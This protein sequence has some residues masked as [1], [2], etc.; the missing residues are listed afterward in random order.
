MNGSSFW[1][2]MGEGQTLGHPMLRMRL[3]P[4]SP[5]PQGTVPLSRATLKQ[6]FH[7]LFSQVQIGSFH[8]CFLS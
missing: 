2:V 5:V 3:E 1:G 4:V 6:A 7:L 8:A